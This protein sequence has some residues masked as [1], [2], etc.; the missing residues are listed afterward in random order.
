MAL[1]WV[2]SSYCADK[3]CVEVALVDADT[4]AVRDGKDVN[5]PLLRFSRED[6]ASFVDD[7]ATGRFEVR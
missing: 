5:Q 7:L 2:K 4:V 1:K 6:W 3:S